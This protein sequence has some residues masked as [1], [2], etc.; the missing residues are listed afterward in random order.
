MDVI[1]LSVGE[2]DFDT[3]AAIIKAGMDALTSGKTRYTPNNGST[4]LKTAI[5][6]KLQGSSFRHLETLLWEQAS[7]CAD[8]NG[9][10]YKPEEILVTNGAKQAIWQAVL[11]TCSPGDE[12]SRPPLNLVLCLLFHAFCVVPWCSGDRSR[13]LLGQLHGDGDSGSRTP[14]HRQHDARGGFHHERREAEGGA[15]AQVTAANPLLAFEPDRSRLQQ[16]RCVSSGGGWTSF[17]LDFAGSNLP[18]SP[19]SSKV[20]PGFLC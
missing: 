13:S 10:E 8:E 1:S 19:R 12:V 14:R 16:V 11:S 3:P 18:L 4:A 5:C 2:P 17:I 6:K 9:L 15:H 20:T 7:L